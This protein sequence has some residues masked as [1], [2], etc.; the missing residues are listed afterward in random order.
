MPKTKR[1]QGQT[2]DG[3][4]HGED[5]AH[6]LAQIV[7]D[8]PPQPDRRHDRAEIIVEQDDGRGL[9]RHVRA[10]PAHGDADMRGLQ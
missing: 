6:R 9:A 7:I 10:A 4:M 3:N 2:G 8:P 5:E 1:Q